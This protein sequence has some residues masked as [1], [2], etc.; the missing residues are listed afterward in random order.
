MSN[1]KPEFNGKAWRTCEYYKSNKK[2]VNYVIELHKNQAKRVVDKA[3]REHMDVPAII[4]AQQV[5]HGAGGYE[6]GAELVTEKAL[7]ESLLQWN[8]IPVVIYHTSESARTIENLENEKVGFIYD[9]ELIGF[10]EE[11]ENIRL[12]CM[13]RLDIQLLELHDD[14]SMIIN[15][16]DSGSIMEMSTGYFVTDWQLQEGSYRGRDYVAMQNKIIPDHLALLPNAIGAYSVNDGGGAN[17]ENEGERMKDSEKKEIAVIANEIVDEKLKEVPS[18]ETIEEMVGNATKEL[19]GKFDKLN[20]KL[21]E[22]LT[23]LEAQENKKKEDEEARKNEA[24]QAKVKKASKV[25]G[26][27]ENELA[28]ATDVVLNKLIEATEDK[29]GL[30]HLDINEVGAGM[31]HPEFNA[32]ETK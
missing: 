31:S 6:F 3:G 5:L 9:A 30:G 2:D 7:E 17:R 11:P 24:R 4:L 19:E 1:K 29:G 27:A 15:T 10:D 14:G 23:N 12:K 26:L 16:F 18:T 21:D 8:N 22:L 25:S 32:K 28:D 13:L 20:E